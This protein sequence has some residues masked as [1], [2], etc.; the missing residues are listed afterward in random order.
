[1]F[2]IITLISLTFIFLSCAGKDP[3]EVDTE[4]PQRANLISH[5]GNTGDII[6]GDTLN[7]CE[8]NGFEHNGIDAVSGEMDKIQITWQHILDNDIDY[9]DIF[10]FNL[11]DNDTLRIG[12]LNTPDQ[13][14]YNDTFIGEDE[15]TQVKWFYFIKVVDEA[16]N[17]SLSDTVAYQLLDQPY[18]I[19]P[20]NNE[21]YGNLNNITF[22]WDKSGE[23]YTNRLLV[24][25]SEYRLK[26][27]YETIVNPEQDQYS[28]DYNG[29]EI[30]DSMIYWR[31]EYIANPNYFT[32]NGIEYEVNIGSESET[33]IIYLD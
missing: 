6:A 4:A 28:V 24:F 20:N 26:W 3:N 10:R 7:Y 8:S 5:K 23:Q 2:K 32:V 19:A 13:D 15:P 31:V 30:N 22:E 33:R 21:L 18:L 12:T 16:G 29:P 11:Q 27:V 17:F 9:I 1:M 14:Y 25:D